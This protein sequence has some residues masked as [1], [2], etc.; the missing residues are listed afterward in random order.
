MTRFRNLAITAALAAS[1]G[2][3]GAPAA[4]AA[5]MG[6]V[7]DLTWGAPD[8]DKE[9]EYA[10]LDDVGARWIRLSA[11]WAEVERE[12]G[13]YNAWSLE[14]IDTAVR[15]NLTAGRRIVLMVGEAPQW[16]SGS[17]Y[18]DTPPQDVADYAR[19]VGFLAERYAGLGIAGYEIWN[20]PNISRFWGNRTPDAAAYVSL[21]QAA[22]AAVRG[23]DPETK[24]VFGGLSTND[25]PYVRAAYAAGAKGLFDVMALHPYTCDERIDVLTRHADGTVPAATFLGYREVRALMVSLGDPRPMWMTELGWSTTTGWCGV[26]EAAQADRLSLAAALVQQDA[27]VESLMVYG[28]RNNYWD[29]DRD[30]LEARFGLMT[31]DFRAKP[32]LAVFKAL[33]LSAPAV[34]PQPP[35]ATPTPTPTPQPP[36]ATPTPTPEPPA[37]PTPTPSRRRPPTPTPEPPAATPTPTPELPT[38]TPVPPSSTPTPAPTLTLKPKQ[39]G[40]GATAQLSLVGRVA[41]A[42]GTAKVAVDVRRGG[43]RVQSQTVRARRGH[44]ELALRGRREG[45]RYVAVARLQGRPHVSSSIHFTF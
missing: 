26:S 1:I 42:G 13:V 15:R 19:F 8:A 45:T 14:Q 34:E 23:A 38:A 20:E 30:T 36:A 4:Q 41:A 32:A 21:L 10:I 27:Y 5:E 16:A 3:A 40:R 28:L 37:A 12:R 43:R 31:T 17:T 24:V 18:Q 2:L 7:T 9:R 11:N 6:L 25:V 22:S 44:F 33:A 39:R 35:T 29:G